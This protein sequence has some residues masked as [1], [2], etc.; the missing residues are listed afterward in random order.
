MSEN[1]STPPAGQPEPDKDQ[2]DLVTELREMG[3]QI[4]AVFRAA[5]ESERAKQLQRDLAGGLRELT[6]Q[7][8]SA[9]KNLQTNPRVQEVEE[10]GRQAISQA[11]QSKVAQDVQE[12]LVNGI[13]QLNERLRVVVDRIEREGGAASTQQVPIEQE[14]PATGPTTRLDDGPPTG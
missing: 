14:P 10:R 6:G 5:L 1:P 11:R 9:L 8:Q 3:Q 7:V 4:E 12:A 13:S 2:P